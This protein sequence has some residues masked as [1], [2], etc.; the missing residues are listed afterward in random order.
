MSFPRRQKAAVYA[1]GA[2]AVFIVCSIVQATGD[3]S[4]FST[5]Y[6]QPDNVLLEFAISVTFYPGWILTIGLLVAAFG[7]IRN[8]MQ[9][10]SRQ[11]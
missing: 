11:R 10:D 6:Y 1:A 7:E 3:S 2:V 8:D 4:M 9:E 5:N